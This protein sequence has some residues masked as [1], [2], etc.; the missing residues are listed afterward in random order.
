MSSWWEK[1]L[2]GSTPAR[3]PMRPMPAPRVDPSNFPQG[4]GQDHDR[5]LQ[6]Y[7]RRQPQPPVQ[8]DYDNYQPPDPGDPHGYHKNMWRWQGNP[9]GGAGD[10]AGVCPNCGSPRYFSRQRSD[11]GSGGV[12]TTAGVV[13]PAPECF[14]CGYPKLQ[15]SI[16]IASSGGSAK[17]A[18]QGTAPAPPG[19]LATLQPPQR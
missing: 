19:S 2:S 10:S 14:E 8:E 18:R 16:G 5:A 17:P 3:P 12:M 4:V 15:G 6:D 13:Y 9:R 11:L 7:L 1:K